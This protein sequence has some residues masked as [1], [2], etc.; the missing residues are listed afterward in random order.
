[1]TILILYL[2]ISNTL[3]EAC[4]KCQSTKK[5]I[6]FF[7]FTH[8]VKFEKYSKY[9]VYEIQLTT[10]ALVLDHSCLLLVVFVIIFREIKNRAT[11]MN[12]YSLG[13]PAFYLRPVAFR[14]RL[15][16][17]LALALLCLESKLFLGPQ[18]SVVFIADN[19]YNICARHVNEFFSFSF[20]TLSSL[21]LGSRMA[22]IIPYL[23]VGLWEMVELCT[24]FFNMLKIFNFISRSK[25]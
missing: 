19:Q 21:P 2:Y 5:S 4:I 24:G 6:Y 15:T 20:N 7:C 8:V 1:V 23:L 25:S 11:K 10:V 22:K 17:G 12:L 13:S 9:I 16:T 3:L 14:P 18:W